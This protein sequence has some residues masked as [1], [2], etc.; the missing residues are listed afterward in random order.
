MFKRLDRAIVDLN[1]LDAGWTTRRDAAE[2]LGEIGQHAL[3]A[4]VNRKDDKDQ[5]VRIAVQKSLG[6]IGD[7]P[8]PAPPEDTDINIRDLARA[9]EKPGK[10]KVTME[11]G[12]FSV[13]VHLKDKRNQTVQVM[14]HNL[15]DG[16]RLLKIFTTC[17]DPKPKVVQWAMRSN[18]N[19]V[20]GAFA[21]HQEGDKE[22][23]LLID[24]LPWDQVTPEEV[25][26][27][28]KEIAFYG[29]WLESKLSG[30]DEF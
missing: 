19:L 8:T 2:A 9:C 26:A 16:K 13:E 11:K 21:I 4:L 10:R 30:S 14:P 17:G 18:A 7:I 24:N 12:R 6:Q 20:R 27:S 5:D 3:A 15:N 25:K 23:L 29:D 28:V 1:D 22:M